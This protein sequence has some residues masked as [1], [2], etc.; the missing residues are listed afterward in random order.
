MPQTV[1]NESRRRDERYLSFNVDALAATIC[2]SIHRPLSDL[3][4]FT[5]LA[6]GGFNRVFE[7]TFKDGYAVVARIPFHI[8]APARYAV[9]SEAAT[10]DFLRSHSIPVPKVLAYS[11]DRSSPVGAEYL[12]LEKIDGRPLSDQWFTMDNKTRVKVMRQIVDVETRFM[13]LTLPASG[14]L[15]YRRDLMP[16]YHG[17]PVSAAF[18]DP[19]QIVVGPTAQHAWWYGERALLE[20]DRWPFELR[21]F[22][23]VD[24]YLLL[25]F[26]IIKGSTF[27]DCMEAVAKRES[28]FCSKYAKPRLHVERYLRELHGFGPR[29]PTTHSQLLSQYL[30]LTPHL[31]IPS[32]HRFA[33]LV[34]WHPDFS[35]SNILVNSSD[36][37][38]GIIDW[39]HAVILPLCLCTGIPKYFQN[40]GDPLSERLAKPEVK[41]PADFATKS[42][43]EQAVIQETMRKGLVQFYYAALTMKQSPDYFD[44]LRDENA[45]LRAKLF[46]R[47]STPWEG[48]SV[49]LKHTIIQIQRNW[50][51]QLTCDSSRGDVEVQAEGVC[52]VSYSDEEILQCCQ[53]HDREDEKMKELE[54]MREMIGIDALGWVPDSEHLEKARAVAN[55]IKTGL[56]EHSTTDIEKTAILKHFSFDDHDESE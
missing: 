50:P 56:L 30:Q 19:D 4:S 35:P 2:S 53:E 27:L 22:F 37:L 47:A 10:L 40:W 20:S 49:S 6:E 1:F 48:N 25:T 31:N 32:T 45:M 54:E 44:A 52:P 9:A 33:R 3:A 38:V 55:M 13:G 16:S 41:L 46:D 28:L 14:S 42:L 23:R 17:I 24:L 29:A 39:Q 8:T 18:Q 26:C 7:A 21:P 12:V 34:L 36:E 5:K 15:Y 11:C 51:M 43:E